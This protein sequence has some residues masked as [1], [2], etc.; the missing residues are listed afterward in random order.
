MC[1]SG[2]EREARRGRRRSADVIAR[3][4]VKVWCSS[5][6]SGK[7]RSFFRS[8]SHSPLTPQKECLT[9]FAAAQE[10]RELSQQP[11]TAQDGSKTKARRNK[12]KK[13]QESSA[14][15]TMRAPCPF[16]YA[17]C[18]C[19]GDRQFACRPQILHRNTSDARGVR[20]E[21]Q[22]ALFDCNKVSDRRPEAGNRAAPLSPALLA[23]QAEAEAGRG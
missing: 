1:Q 7:E 12:A 21:R 20:G 11:A 5:P 8:S 19:F 3:S 14:A 17:S 15:A 10:N 9:I 13:A 4:L 6:R 23:G 16:L 18:A 2:R 22:N